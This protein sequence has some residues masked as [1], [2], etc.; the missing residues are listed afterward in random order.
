MPTPKKPK[1]EYQTLP[2][3]DALKRVWATPP[4]LYASVAELLIRVPDALVATS[5]TAPKIADA[6]PP[7]PVPIQTINTPPPV[8]AP[9]PPVFTPPAVVAAPPPVFTPPPVVNPPPPVLVE[10]V[11]PKPPPPPAEDILIKR[12]VTREGIVNRAVS[13]QSP[14]H[15]ILESL[16][17]KK[18]INYL[19]SPSTN[20]A[21]K[22][23]FGQRILIT[24]EELLDERWPNT[25]VINVET[26][27][28]VE[29]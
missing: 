5:A 26:L 18:T 14:T 1:R 25:P 24:G 16:D 20:I 23:F 13:V 28:P 22:S 6:T 19:Y 29:Q 8:V 3:N 11:T 10:V 15:F 12:V 4:T 2:F 9:P 7:P 17:N 27:Q 21:L